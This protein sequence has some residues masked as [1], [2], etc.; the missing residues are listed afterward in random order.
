MW[1]WTLPV[2]A[3]WWVGSFMMMR[4]LPPQRGVTAWM[5]RMPA[6]TMGSGPGSWPSVWGMRWRFSPPVWWSSILW[7]WSPRSLQMWWGSMRPRVQA[8]PWLWSIIASI[9]SS[10][11]F[12]STL[13]IILS[14]QGVRSRSRLWA[15]T[16]GMGWRSRSAPFLEGW[17]WREFL[18]FLL[19]WNLL[20]WGLS[21]TTRTA[22]W[23]W[24]FRFW[25]CCCADCFDL[26]DG[27]DKPF[28]AEPQGN[29]WTFLWLE[30]AESLQVVLTLKKAW[31]TCLPFCD[32][33]HRDHFLIWLPLTS[34]ECWWV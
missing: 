21:I 20:I 15:F 10:W 25:F 2:L 16:P 1:T 28:P 30:S 5:P 22:W 24:I 26:E 14:L 13:L 19:R 8:A 34:L 27:S 29:L 6:L 23:W 31:V 17:R 12:R 7:A 4:W 33:N 11:R 3:F 32:W 18:H 9:I